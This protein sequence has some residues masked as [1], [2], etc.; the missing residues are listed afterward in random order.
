ME[1]GQHPHCW[2]RD[3]EAAFLLQRHHPYAKST[4]SAVTS[5]RPCPAAF[6]LRSNYLSFGFP[7]ATE[8]AHCCLRWPVIGQGARIA[9]ALQ[10]ALAGLPPARPPAPALWATA[11]VPLLLFVHHPQDW[12]LHSYGV[13]V[14]S[15]AGNRTK[16]STG[17]EKRRRQANLS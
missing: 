9:A 3:A 7:R 1:E 10:P 13:I 16:H 5:L 4:F 2:K 11:I 14:A 8:R 12:Q 17:T 15:S 6:L